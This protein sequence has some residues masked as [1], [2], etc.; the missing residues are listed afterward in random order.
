[1]QF[2]LTCPNPTLNRTKSKTKYQFLGLTLL[3]RR[4]IFCQYFQLIFCQYFQL[5][6]LPIF[7]P[8]FCQYLQPIVLSILPI[9][10]CMSN[11]CVS[12]ACPQCTVCEMDIYYL[13]VHSALYAKQL[14]STLNALFV[15][16]LCITCELNAKQVVTTCLPIV[17]CM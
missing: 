5:I 17:H 11:S 2:S 16:Q 7:S 1:M 15:K 13:L 14:F 10:H 8:F 4:S 6:F 12:L 3:N 9:V